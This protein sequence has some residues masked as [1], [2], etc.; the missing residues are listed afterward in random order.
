MSV[1]LSRMFFFSDAD[2]GKSL[3]VSGKSVLF[4]LA[5]GVTEV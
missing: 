1:V 2:V 5:I 3:D 4:V